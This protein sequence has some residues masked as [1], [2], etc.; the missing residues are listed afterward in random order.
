MDAEEHLIRAAGDDPPSRD[1]KKEALALVLD[2]ELG[3]IEEGKTADLVLF[4]GEPLDASTRVT[5]VFV[6]GSLAYALGR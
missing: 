5:A 1:L 6:G 2:G 3:T 4:D